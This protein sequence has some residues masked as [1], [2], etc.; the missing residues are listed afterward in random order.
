MDPIATKTFPASIVVEDRDHGI[1]LQV[2]PPAEGAEG[3]SLDIH[4]SLV[5]RTPE[6][7]L[8]SR[9]SGSRNLDQMVLDGLVTIDE[10]A[11]VRR[12]LVICGVS[13]AAENGCDV[14][15]PTA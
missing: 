12:V 6:G 8:I 9:A 14:S 10:V 3:A 4:M 5:M 11:T 1:T 15:N 13:I 7:Q 2:R